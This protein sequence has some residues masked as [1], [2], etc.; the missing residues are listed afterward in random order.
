MTQLSAPD[1]PHD[2]RTAVPSIDE[3][4]RLAARC[5]AAC[6]RGAILLL[7]GLAIANAL[8]F[9][10]GRWWFGE[11]FC[12]FQWQYLW[13]GTLAAGWFAA[14]RRWRWMLAGLLFVALH[15]VRL[16]PYLFPESPPSTVSSAA[17]VERTLLHWNVFI[18]NPT[19]PALIAA[20][21]ELDPD[22]VL[23]EEIGDDWERSLQALSARYPYAA[24]RSDGAPFG[25]AFFSKTPLADLR[26]LSRGE[27]ENF[28]VATTPEGLTIIGA[29]VMS[30]VGKRPA[31][32]RNRQLRELATIVGHRTAP[33]ILA[34]DFNVT[35]WSPHYT[36]L[37][38]ATGL[39]DPRR[40]FGRIPTWPNWGRVF[41]VPIDHIL[42]TPDVE[43]VSLECPPR[44]CGSDHRPL[45]GR[46]RIA[47]RNSTYPAAS[48]PDVDDRL[49]DAG[50]GK[51]VGRERVDHLVE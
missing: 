2:V 37:R 40:Q 46:F 30:P 12:H 19:H 50:L 21:V 43:F 48:Q 8:S 1:P 17:S 10:A 18:D 22:F 35:P 7:S 9:A 38:D 41:Q 39:R 49:H 34:G 5:L 31:G 3:D 15:T 4:E 23:L 28:V 51:S 42:A 29:H 47:P 44:T 24:I 36:D 45:V 14:R 25:I 11:L 32:L 20:I 16:H 13:I 33:L 6:D 27:L 26:I